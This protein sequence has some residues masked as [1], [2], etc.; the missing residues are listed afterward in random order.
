VKEC[1][2]FNLIDFPGT[3]DTSG[4]EIRIGMD[5]AFREM[6]SL[7]KPAHVLGLL[8]IESFNVGRGTAAKQQ[9]SKL[10]RLLPTPG[11]ALGADHVAGKGSAS[12]WKVGVTKCDKDFMTKPKTLFKEAEKFL[13]EFDTVL[14]PHIINMN[15]L[16]FSRKESTRKDLIGMLLSETH[17][18]N[19]HGLAAWITKKVWGGDSGDIVSDCLNPNDT[20]WFGSIFLSEDFEKSFIQ[21]DLAQVKRCASFADSPVHGVEDSTWESFSKSVDMQ[22]MELCKYT[23]NIIKDSEQLIDHGTLSLERRSLA[24]KKLCDFKQCRLKLCF[25]QAEENIM[26]SNLRSSSVLNKELYKSATALW[27]QGFIRDNDFAEV[28]EAYEK[29]SQT[30]DQNARLVGF[31]DTKALLDSA[32]FMGGMAAMGGAITGGVTAACSTTLAGA[33][34]GTGT[35]STACFAGLTTGGLSL[36]IGAAVLGFATFAKQCRAHG[37]TY[38]EKMRE[39]MKMAFGALMRANDA[40]TKHKTALGG[41]TSTLRSLEVQLRD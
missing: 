5:I 36:I 29:S 15:E 28:K 4:V 35:L 20:A 24:I 39:K 32:F 18:P 21:H 23:D 3:C 33:W 31:T 9:I 27:N 17:T 10:Q 30:M 16:M 8:P 38:S 2:D 1:G 25:V 14:G 34:A 26:M 6:V 11:A 7:V 19:R 37:D 22:V 41:M 12:T 13:I 40:A